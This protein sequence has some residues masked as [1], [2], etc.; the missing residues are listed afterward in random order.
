MQCTCVYM[1]ARKCA[2]MGLETREHVLSQ[3]L[4]TQIFETGPF[5][6]LKFDK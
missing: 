3:A 4:A 2:S 1:H 6:G 5:T